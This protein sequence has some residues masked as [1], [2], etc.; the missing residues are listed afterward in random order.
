MRILFTCVPQ[1]GHILP[2]LPLAEA[3]VAQG[4]DVLFVTG[5]DAAAP[6]TDRGID[7]RVGG[8]SFAEWYAR[9]AARTRGV[10]G[11]G[12]APDRVERYFLPRLF[13]EVGTAALLDDLLE[14]GKEFRPD[15]LAFDPF[16]YAAPLAAAVLGVPAVLHSIGPL[17]ASET[18]ELVADAVSPIWREFG[19]DVPVDAGSYGGRVLTICPPSLDPAA[20]QLAN[21]MPLR[22]TPLPY[23]AGRPPDLPDWLWERP[24]V[25]ATLGTFSNTNAAVFRLFF[26][27]LAELDANSVVTIGRDNDPATLG[28]I[29]PNVHVAQF[30]AQADL[31][32]HCTAALHHAGAGTSFG[33]LAHGLP[34]VAV[35]QSADNFTIAARLSAAGAARSLMP[36]EVTKEGLG[37]A[38]RDVLERAEVRAAARQLADQISCMPGPSQVAATLATVG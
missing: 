12:L 30:I 4:D 1:T 7:F 33:I 10:P 6:V 31:L 2:L 22:P 15:L 23:A 14:A 16:A 37:A 34:S 19:K 36:H 28:E 18:V 9:L 17:P 21:A 20:A 27:V 8:P 25:Y 5:S 13:G 35:P 24:V 11:D 3:F 32:P 29:P 26:D 38:L